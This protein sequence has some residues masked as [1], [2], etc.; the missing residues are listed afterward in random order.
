MV[1]VAITANRWNTQD[2][3]WWRYLQYIRG[4]IKYY[5][6]RYRETGIFLASNHTLSLSFNPYRFHLF[7]LNCFFMASFAIFINF[8]TASQLFC[9]PSRKS[10]SFDN[11]VLTIRSPF[12]GCLPKFNLNEM[13][14]VAICFLLLYWNLAINNHSVQLSCW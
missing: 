12:Y 10:S 4:L 9:S 3:N 1:L 13:Y 5:T 8:F 11:F 14:P 6:Q 7:L 2:T